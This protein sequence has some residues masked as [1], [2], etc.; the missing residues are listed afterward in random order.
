MQIVFRLD[1]SEKI[2]IGH[3]SRCKN[4]ASYLSKRGAKIHF[5]VRNL[6]KNLSNYIK[7]KNFKISY[8]KKNSKFEKILN[9][10][11]DKLWPNKL[12]IIDAFDTNN[13]IAKKKVDWLIV[14]HY[15][16]NAAWE[17]KL[18]KKVKNIMVIGDHL[19]RKH[20]CDLFLFQ[21]Y[22]KKKINL[23]KHLPKTS[24]ILLGPKFSLLDETYA[25][26]RKKIRLKKNKVKNIF[27]SFGGTNANNLILKIIDIFK[28]AEF[29]KINLLVVTPKIFFDHIKLKKFY[30]RSNIKILSSVKTLSKLIFNS[31]FCIGAGGT[32]NWERMC[33][34]LPTLVL[35]IASNQMSIS[36]NLEKEKLIYLIKNF[37]STNSNILKKKLIKILK[38]D[39]KLY[40]MKQ[41]NLSMV[42]GLGGLRLAEI[43]FPSNSSK[44]KLRK[45]N[46]RD[47]Y[48]YF[49]WVN[50]K[51]VIKN[52]FN[53]K[54]INIESH[55]NWFK[56]QI[57]D[58]DSYMYVLEINK[59]PIGQVRFNV[60]K[61][62]A[63]I[64]YSLDETIRGRGLG[65]TLINFGLKKIR[66]LKINL[67]NA[68]VKSI[69]FK[70]KLIFKN[71]G[72]KEIKIKSKYI[73]SLTN[74]L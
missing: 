10:S 62:N 24:K 20:N 64:D 30:N 42:D 44:L 8:L 23:E 71:L 53:K 74:S 22:N 46:L 38:N 14:D 11:E 29:K 59:L 40:E 3:F 37:A 9:L 12:Q 48:T 56:N 50:E 6:N 49:N 33:L 27:T 55:K 31:D 57:K 52:S 63:L 2:G 28:S 15:G 17:N 36:S 26:L 45:A 34:G 1:A 60:N 35:P 67:V 72:F 16:L 18:K 32:T 58:K 66:P 54:T 47:L 43:L 61:K 41:K 13:I 70:S 25:S 69:N 68:E 5:I 21:N 7:K 39:K 73:Y 4:L 51:E 65:K 19:N